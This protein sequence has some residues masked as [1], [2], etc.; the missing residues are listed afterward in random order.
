MNPV[1]RRLLDDIDDPELADFALAWDAFE[2]MIVRI[3]RAG[4]SSPEDAEAFAGRRRSIQQ[5]VDHWDAA[6]DPH[7]RPVGVNVALPPESP[8]RGILRVE[9]ASEIVGNWDL[10]RLLPPAREALNGLL[11]NRGRP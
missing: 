6:L 9:H 10:L 4:G 3:Y 1:T 2:E 8:F 11:I 7:W 5:V